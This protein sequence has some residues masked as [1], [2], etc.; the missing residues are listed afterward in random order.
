MTDALQAGFATA[1]SRLVTDYPSYSF[2]TNVQYDVRSNADRAALI[3]STLDGES[4]CSIACFGLASLLPNKSFLVAEAARRPHVLFAVGSLSF[5]DSNLPSNVITYEALCDKQWFAAGVVVALSRPTEQ[6]VMVIPDSSTFSYVTHAFASGAHYAHNG[7][8]RSFK[9][10]LAVPVNS[11]SS[12]TLETTV[13]QLARNNG[14]TVISH[15]SESYAV[16]EAAHRDLTYYSVGWNYGEATKFVGSMLVSI[17]RT[18]QDAFYDIMSSWV[19]NA[20]VNQSIWSLTCSMTIGSTVSS[21]VA[22]FVHNN[23]SALNMSEILWGATDF[24]GQSDDFMFSGPL[25]DVAVSAIDFVTN[26]STLQPPFLGAAS[27]PNDYEA[28]F[29]TSEFFF[30]TCTRCPPNYFSRG[31]SACTECTGELSSFCGVSSSQDSQT[32]ILIV[33]LAVPLGLLL[34]LI[35]ALICCWRAKVLF[36]NKMRT[37]AVAEPRKESVAE[38]IQ[39][40]DHAA[41]TADQSLV[42]TRSWDDEHIRMSIDNNEFTV[43]Q[44]PITTLRSGAQIFKCFLNNGTTIG[45]LLVRVDRS[46]TDEIIK[47]TREV[48]AHPNI[49]RV[50]KVRYNADRALAEIFVE[51]DSFV[52]LDAMLQE[53]PTVLNEIAVR[54]FMRHVLLGLTHLHRNGVAHRDIR[55]GCVVVTPDAGAK[56]LHTGASRR[57]DCNDRSLTIASPDLF[58]PPEMITGDIPSD[59][60]SRVAFQGDIWKLGVCC[61]EILNKGRVPWADVTDKFDTELTNV[62]RLVVMEAVRNGQRP[63]LPAGASPQLRQ[64]VDACTDPDPQKR[65]PAEELL[66][67]QWLDFSSK[68]VGKSSGSVPPGTAVEK[69][70]PSLE[71]DVKGPIG[72]GACGTVHEI[73]TETGSKRALKA[74]TFDRTDQR[75]IDRLRRT[76]REVAAL[77]RLQHPNLIQY[78]SMRT[79]TRGSMTLCYIEMELVEGGSLRNFVSTNSPLT[80]QDVRIISKSILS[81]VSFVHKNNIIHRDIKPG[82]IL[83]CGP[84]EYVKLA[85]FGSA[86]LLNG[87]TTSNGAQGTMMYMAP[88]IFREDKP[89][90]AADIWSTGVTIMELATN[91]PPWFHMTGSTAVVAVLNLINSETTLKL[92]QSIDAS[93]QDLLSKMLCREPMHRLTAEELLTH[94]Y[95]DE[96]R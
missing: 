41:T 91:K 45:V 22:N 1:V 60:F 16:S 29:G 49:V 53:L 80:T 82:N 10:L 56:L 90:F 50:F 76:E 31:G 2:F 5:W 32:V 20:T 8:N 43:S 55:A 78:H 4:N 77:T 51:M 30:V 84:P 35:V 92:P 42:S 37:E 67:H 15:T 89:T 94:P 81:G 86:A 7:A 9:A 58:M 85:D 88:E 39:V 68:S 54:S 3:T 71:Y 65:P 96:T 36:F 11:W 47:A 17:D 6:H 59:D 70:T 46:E 61:A 21:D 23:V 57:F 12:A 75:D 19:I 72:F 87:T 34:L 26:A 40:S 93:L 28:T 14:T 18:Y 25:S 74:M 63:Q 48:P 79:E 73:R 13:A 95:F 33:A 66:H 69:R 44:S 62:E 52:F 27:C 64:F 24:F 38:P 83:Y